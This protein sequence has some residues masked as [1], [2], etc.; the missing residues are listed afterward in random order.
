VIS[1]RGVAD[2]W[3][4]ATYGLAAVGL[5]VGASAWAVGL[6]PSLS[7]LLVPLSVAGVILCAL[8]VVVRRPLLNGWATV[9]VATALMAGE[10]G[11]PVEVVVPAAYAV[12]LLASTELAWRSA[13]LATTQDWERG[14]LRRWW[15]LMGALCPGG[16]A[17]AVLSG[18]VGSAAL[19]AGSALA[20]LGGAGV[21][22]LGALVLRG[23]QRLGR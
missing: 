7:G 9:L 11:R 23:V 15:W 6:R 19:G 5:E 10:V 1:S 18:L 16:F 4:R 8:G 14:A 2:R 13:Q 22:A 3:R 20:V 17:V 21:L 12:L